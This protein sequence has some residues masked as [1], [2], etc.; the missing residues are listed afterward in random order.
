MSLYFVWLILVSLLLLHISL[1]TAAVE[2]FSF[3]FTAMLFLYLHRQKEKS[4]NFSS[5]CLTSN[6][7]RKWMTMHLARRYVFRFGFKILFWGAFLQFPFSDPR[8][9]RDNRLL[10]DN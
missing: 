4:R 7:W 9:A 1:G 2:F 10:L 6:L 3:P 8:K 5:N